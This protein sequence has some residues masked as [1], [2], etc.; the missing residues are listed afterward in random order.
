MMPPHPLGPHCSTP[1]HGPQFD[2]IVISVLL[3]SIASMNDYGTN[4][5]AAIYIY[6]INEKENIS[7]SYN[8][9]GCLN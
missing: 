3:F 9:I 1:Q 4:G 2:S 5:N 8:S 7:I 6:V